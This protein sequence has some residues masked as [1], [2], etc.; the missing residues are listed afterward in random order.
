MINKLAKY[1]EPM[2]WVVLG[3]IFLVMF[4]W[5]ALDM[6]KGSILYWAIPAGILATIG[7]F[8]NGRHIKNETARRRQEFEEMNKRHDKMLER[9]KS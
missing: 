2:M 9:F 3:S 8:L 5:K 7:F 4:I 6:P 1:G